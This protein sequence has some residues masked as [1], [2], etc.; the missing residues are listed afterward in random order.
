MIK[1]FTLS[2]IDECILDHQPKIHTTLILW[3]THNMVSYKVKL[4]GRVPIAQIF[5]VAQ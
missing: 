1:T 2:N 4:I 3:L 5:P